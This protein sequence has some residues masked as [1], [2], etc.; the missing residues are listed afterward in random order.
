MA[1]SIV[2]GDL[3]ANQKKFSWPEIFCGKSRGKPRK[4]NFFASILMYA[5]HFRKTS[6]ERIVNFFRILTFKQFFYLFVFPA[7]FYVLATFFFLRCKRRSTFS[8]DI[9]QIAEGWDKPKVVGRFVQ[10]KVNV[11][12]ALRTTHSVCDS[13]HPHIWFILKIHDPNH[14]EITRNHFNLNMSFLMSLL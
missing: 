13:A 7:V 6:S 3:H 10:V 5:K 4:I 12:E 2:L 14:S 1:R 9:N 11:Y 8:C